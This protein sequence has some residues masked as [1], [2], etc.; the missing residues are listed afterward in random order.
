MDGTGVTVEN[1][2]TVGAGRPSPLSLGAYAKHRGISKTAVWRAVRSG[3]LK[4]CLVFDAKGDAKVADVARADQEWTAATDLTKAPTYVKLRAEGKAAPPPPTAAP[5]PAPSSQAAAPT[6]DPPNDPP[7]DD[8]TGT[9]TLSDALAREKTWKSRTA[10]LEY[11]ERS[12]ALVN[13]K[14][15][16]AQIVEEYG[17]CRTKLLGLSRKA[18]AVL[19]HLTHA[20]V[21]AIDGLI[22]EALE[23]LADHQ[24]PPDGPPS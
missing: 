23:D 1:A 6:D 8:G 22:R 17:R 7:G 14:D 15:V 5:T 3:R 10:E 4:K 9:L 12:G 20:D 11:K 2:G 19:P 16:E 18:K 24:P 13:A 21:A